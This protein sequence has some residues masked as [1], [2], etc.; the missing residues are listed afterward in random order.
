MLL[1]LFLIA[2]VGV[3]LTAAAILDS[4]QARI[5]RESQLLFVGDQYRRA[6]REYYFMSPGSPH[7]PPSIQDLLKDPR[8]PNV[9]RHLREAY[10][11]P[12]TGRPFGLIPDP[13]GQG[14]QG[15]F[16]EAPGEPLKIDG[17]TVDDGKF[18]GATRYADWRFEFVPSVGVPSNAQGISG[19]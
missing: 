14:I 16:S 4:T 7:Y 19:R 2:L 5:E 3:S 12:L 6:I 1:A 10:A 8:Y 17:F 13:V 18:K 11:D 15:V 9:V